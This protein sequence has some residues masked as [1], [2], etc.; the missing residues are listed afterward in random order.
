M[1]KFIAEKKIYMLKRTPPYFWP[2][3]LLLVLSITTGTKKPRKIR[4]FADINAKQE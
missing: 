1:I 2:V 4:A 3:F